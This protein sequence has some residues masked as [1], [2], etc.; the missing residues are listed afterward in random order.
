MGINEKANEKGFRKMSDLNKILS[1]SENLPE[2]FF[3]E[4]NEKDLFDDIESVTEGTE[5]G[6]PLKTETAQPQPGE[7]LPGQPGQPVQPGQGT[8]LDKVISGST[9]VTVVDNLLPLLIVFIFKLGGLGKI[10]KKELQLTAAEKREL[11]P[12]LMLCLAEMK[13][14]FSNP[15]VQFFTL[16][17]VLYGTKAT[18]IALK[19]SEKAGE[20]KKSEKGSK[21][22]KTGEKRGGGRHK[23]NC[24]WH[25]GNECNCRG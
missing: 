14:N 2:S 6:N 15:F 13:I 17:G 3:D 10:S 1:E 11:E 22:T 7:A 21:T 12:S 9:A 23:A 8:G 16:A 18:E 5:T 20:G 25:N 19:E 4:V 24:D